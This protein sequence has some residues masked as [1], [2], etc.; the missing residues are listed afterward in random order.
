MKITLGTTLAKNAF[1]MHCVDERGKLA[2]DKQSRRDQVAA[3]LVICR[4]ARSAWRLAAAR[5]TA[6]K[7][8]RVYRRQ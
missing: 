4:R 8:Q 7:L 6:R 2:L 1:Q 3:L 5:F